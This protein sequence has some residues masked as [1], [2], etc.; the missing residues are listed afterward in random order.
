MDVKTL[1]AEMAKEYKIGVGGDRCRFT[2]VFDHQF[3]LGSTA[4]HSTFGY[5]DIPEG[6]TLQGVIEYYPTD[7]IPQALIDAILSPERSPWRR[8]VGGIKIHRGLKT[9][10]YYTPDMDHDVKYIMSMHKSLRAITEMHGTYGKAVVDFIKAGVD[11]ITALFFGELYYANGPAAVIHQ[12]AGWHGCILQSPD[13]GSLKN[14]LNG[15]TP[16]VSGKETPYRKTDGSKGYMGVDSIFNDGNGTPFDGYFNDGNGTP[17]D[18]YIKK[19]YAKLINP[20][21]KVQGRFATAQVGGLTFDIL[22]KIAKAEYI[23]IMDKEDEEDE[24]R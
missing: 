6:Q 15:V 19:K 24:D 11:P 5:L 1:E 3:K 20:E 18:G 2:F 17:F 16:G 13:S 23:D 9:S 7:M 21:A 14:F 8:M 10:S 12:P 4:C 22:V